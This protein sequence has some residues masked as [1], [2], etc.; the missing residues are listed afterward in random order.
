MAKG[1]TSRDPVADKLDNVLPILQDLFIL[2]GLRAG[3][4]VGDIRKILH[5]DKQRVT[6]ISKHVKQ[7]SRS[8]NGR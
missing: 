1:K 4:T 5:I 2:E 7:A 6:N 3:M 8:G